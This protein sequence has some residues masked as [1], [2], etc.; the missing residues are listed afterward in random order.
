LKHRP[1]FTQK[2]SRVDDWLSVEVKTRINFIFASLQLQTPISL[3]SFGILH[4][5]KVKAIVN[6]TFNTTLQQFQAAS[7]SVV[8]AEAE[9]VLW[10]AFQ[11]KFC[12]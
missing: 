2:N 7:F 1:K 9:D 8:E 5:E 6:T 10:K 12:S 11:I 3:K 4:F